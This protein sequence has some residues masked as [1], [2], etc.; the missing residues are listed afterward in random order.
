MPLTQEEKSLLRKWK[1]KKSDIHKFEV[2]DI[3]NILNVS[4]DRAEILKGL[5]TF[6]QIPS[7][8]YE[9]AYKIVHHLG[10]HSLEQLKDKQWAEVVNC[11]ELK[12]GCWTDPCVEDQIIC[13]IHYANH[14][15][16]EKQW[17]NFTNERKVYRQQN[18]YPKSRPKLAWYENQN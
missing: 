6:Q 5:A 11:L 8:G 9:L 2:Q 1:I 13:I 4:K 17:F 16:S 3:I 10:Y 18:G 15:D 7:I 14:P 12:M